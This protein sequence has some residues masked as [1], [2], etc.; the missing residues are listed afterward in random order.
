MATAKLTLIGL[1]NY[2]PNIFKKLVLP[3]GI[4][5]DILIDNV[6]IRSGD[7]EL[8]YPDPD[9]M[10]EAIGVW[11]QKWQRTFERW[12]KALSINYEPLFNYDRTETWITKDTT[13]REVQENKQDIFTSEMSGERSETE[14][15]NDLNSENNKS[16][17]HGS[18][19]NLSSVEGEKTDKVSAFNSSVF[20]N[21]K[22]SND[23]NQSATITNTDRSDDSND[24]KIGKS[25]RT[26][27]LQDDSRTQNIDVGNST[28][29][30]T[31]QNNNT[32]AGRAY[33]NIG[34]TTSQQMLAA[35][36]DIAH[37][38]IYEHITDLFLSEFI[39]PVFN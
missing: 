22:Q 27:S 17:G 29:E 5:R 11:S 28:V 37:W 26:G 18:D 23:L 31:T 4:D 33:G 30:G 39:I 32:R 14:I 9:F 20:E 19:V 2:N 12:I 3:A 13:N 15:V 24:V 35:E 38:N 1:Y 10:S 7:F 36:L 34:V 21:D 16:Q 25:D 8:L 6:L